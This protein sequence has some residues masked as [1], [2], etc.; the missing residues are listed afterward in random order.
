VAK[1]TKVIT[2][3]KRNGDRITVTKETSTLKK[4]TTGTAVVAGALA[5]LALLGS[6]K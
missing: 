3:T 4:V 2:K 5:V 6:K 1:T